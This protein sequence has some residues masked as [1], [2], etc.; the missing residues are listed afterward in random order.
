M[1]NKSFIDMYKIL[2]HIFF[3][4]AV[5]RLIEFNKNIKNMLI[6]N[7]MCVCTLILKRF[8]KKEK[9]KFNQ[10]IVSCK[11]SNSNA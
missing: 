11:L 7:F 1:Q 8:D 9:K 2:M 6:R 3:L 10:R 4:A 5:S